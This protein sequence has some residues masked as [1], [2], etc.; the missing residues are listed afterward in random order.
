VEGLDLDDYLDNEK[1]PGELVR[2]PVPQGNR[3]PDVVN[4]LL[5]GYDPIIAA[6]MANSY[7]KDPCSL[8]ALCARNTDWP[9]PVQVMMWIAE[10]PEFKGMMAVAR[11]I[12]AD[13]L[14]FRGI[15]ELDSVEI[16]FENAQTAPSEVSLARGKAA[17]TQ[18]L[19]AQIDPERWGK[20]PKE[21]ELPEKKASEIA[22]GMTEREALEVYQ[23]TIA[24]GG[25]DR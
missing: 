15:S 6:E 4:P 23:S 8:V 20:A 18:W 11:A 9:E 2:L 1:R 12:A 21:N 3:E 16:G 7:A 14:A 17:Q 22:A 25:N 10:I 19:A 24:G 13:H 5:A